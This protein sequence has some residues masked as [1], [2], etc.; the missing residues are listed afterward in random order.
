MDSHSYQLNNVFND[1]I[2]GYC[3]DFLYNYS[4]NENLI[5]IHGGYNET[6]F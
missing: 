2:V 5:Y 4:G 1:T 3:V 6:V